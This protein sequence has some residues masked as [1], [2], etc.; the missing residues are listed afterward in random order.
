MNILPSNGIT[1][2][3]SYFTGNLKSLTTKNDNYRKVITTTTNMQ[4]VVMS[5]NKDEDIGAE[6]HPTTSQF[7]FVELGKVVA[8]IGGSEPIN[9]E[10]GDHII[11]PPNTMHNIINK[12]NEVAKL[13]TIYTPPEHPSNCVEPTKTNHAECLRMIGQHG[14]DGSGGGGGGLHSIVHYTQGKDDYLKL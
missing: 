12:S 10:E 8:I 6:T 3:M 4:L 11:I 2:R 5:L 7:I 14:G 9:L 13:Y 1:D